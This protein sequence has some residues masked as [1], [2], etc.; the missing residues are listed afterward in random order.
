VLLNAIGWQSINVLV[1]PIA[2]LA[3]LMLGWG[4]MGRS[5]AGKIA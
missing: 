3:I 5:A 4:G 2:T 1:I